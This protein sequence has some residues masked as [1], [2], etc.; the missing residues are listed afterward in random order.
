MKFV[1]VFTSL[2]VIVF[3]LAFIILPKSS[4]SEIENRSLASFPELDWDDIKDGDYMSDV[5]T[6]LSDHFPLKNTFVNSKT[7]FEQHV[8]KMD[9]INN[10]YIGNLGWTVISSALCWYSQ[11]MSMTSRLMVAEN[12]D[13]CLRAF[14]SS[15]MWRTSL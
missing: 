2:I 3:L 12:M 1:P 10:I 15:M 7:Q 6:Y 13:R 9:C 8:L 5:S 11:P 14:I 4:F